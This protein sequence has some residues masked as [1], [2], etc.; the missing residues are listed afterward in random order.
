[1][2]QHKLI[3]STVSPVDEGLDLL[4]IAIPVALLVLIIAIIVSG[5]F[6]YRRLNRHS[7]RFHLY[8]CLSVDQTLNTEI[9]PMFEEDV[10]SV[11]ELEMDQLDGWMKKDETSQFHMTNPD[12][13]KH[14]KELHKYSEI[15]M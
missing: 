8:P 7:G 4:L 9:K 13:L 5:I 14:G 10:P 6:I 2:I 1:M 15:C 12:A 11:L 3:T